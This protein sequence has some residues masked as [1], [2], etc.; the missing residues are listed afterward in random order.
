MGS[1][2]V[3]SGQAKGIRLRTVP[4]D[5]TRPI[6]DRVK[7]SLFNI[8]GN[9]IIGSSILDMFAGTGAVGIEALSRGANFACFL[10][11]NN[12]AI[13]IINSNLETTQLKQKSVVKRIDAFHFIQSNPSQTFDLIYIAP[14]QYKDLWQKAMF[15][16][17]DNPGW[18]AI[19]GQI[20]VQIDPKEQKDLNLIH[21][22][23]IDNRRYGDTLLLFFEFIN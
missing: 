15:G 2:R 19:N 13:S 22:K 21:F 3:I 1:L 14:P 23:I 11:I 9:E 10:E 20:I 16:F 6:T 7:E 8:I 18:L 17:D 4:G 12:K 5:S